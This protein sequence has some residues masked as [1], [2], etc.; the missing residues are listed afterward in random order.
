MKLREILSEFSQPKLANFIQ[1]WGG[2]IQKSVSKNELIDQLSALIQN[3]VNLEKAVISLTDPGRNLLGAVL[4]C[5]GNVD[6][7]RLSQL[8]K[9]NELKYNFSFYINHLESRG[10]FSVK[11]SRSNANIIVPEE[12]MAPLKK[13]LVEYMPVNHI[14]EEKIVLME[15]SPIIDDIFRI[16]IFSQNKGGIRLTQQ[17]QIFKK[18]KQELLNILGMHHE[19]RL[20][21]AIG[22]M[23]TCYLLNRDANILHTQDENV[24][25]IFSKSKERITIDL[26]IPIIKMHRLNKELVIKFLDIL[27]LNRDGSWIDFRDFIKT[28]KMSFFEKKDVEGWLEFDI[29]KLTQLVNGLYFLG[30]LDLKYYEILNYAHIYSFKVSPFGKRVLEASDENKEVAKRSNRSF[31]VSP[32]FEINVFGEEPDYYT[33][34]RLGKIAQMLRF[35]TACTFRLEK[36]FVLRELTDGSTLPDIISFLEQHSKKELPQNV[37]YSILDWGSK[38]GKV[39]AGK[40]YIE[41]IDRSLCG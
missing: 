3:P 40:G 37:R 23:T 13:L 5:D 7:A 33:M 11:Y 16:C 38:F 2:R 41:I 19:N 31:I 12:L 8:S 27:N 10:L 28:Q 29:Y 20:E 1:N 21:F 32:N 25:T 9:G 39:A 34:Y 6:Y 30:I 36:E 26:I 35:D 18:A 24:R 15:A 22:I 4:M 17:G 14:E